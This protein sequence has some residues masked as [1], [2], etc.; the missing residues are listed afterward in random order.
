MRVV[1]L[2]LTT[3]LLRSCVKVEAAALGFPSLISLMVS[4]CG[5][6]A[7]LERCI[8]LR[9]RKSSQLSAL[10]FTTSSLTLK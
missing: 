3:L 5:R 9:V 2:A 10:V 1:S 8:G 7:T 6:K 4:Q